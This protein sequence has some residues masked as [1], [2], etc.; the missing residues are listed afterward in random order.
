MRISLFI[1]FCCLPCI[2]LSAQWDK[3]Y[4][5]GITVSAEL[6]LEQEPMISFRPLVLLSS[7][8][9]RSISNR[10]TTILVA[11]NGD[12]LNY[13]FRDGTIFRDRAEDHSQRYNLQLRLEKKMLSGLEFGGGVFLS[14]G[15]YSTRLEM[16]NTDLEDFALGVSD[17]NYLKVGLTGSMKFHLLRTRRLQPFAGIQALFLYERNQR[18][19]L[20]LIFS[21]S[22]QETEQD[23]DDHIGPDSVF[24]LDLRLLIGLDYPLT[25]RLHLGL[26]LVPFGAATQQYTGVQLKY[27]TSGY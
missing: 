26:H 23:L 24:V 27:L 6:G 12:T 19:N 5:R 8:E 16:P 13:G 17:V 15:R 7:E 22:E 2:H 9:L 4:H 3:V 10:F 18:S 25:E 1:V 11:Q 21:A 14:E 20:G